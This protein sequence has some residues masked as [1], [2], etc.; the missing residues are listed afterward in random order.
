MASVSDC[1]SRS[2]AARGTQMPWIFVGLIY[3]IYITSTDAIHLDGQSF[4]EMNEEEKAVAVKEMLQKKKPDIPPGKE[5]QYRKDWQDFK[6]MTEKVHFSVKKTVMG[7]RA[8]ADRL[9]EVWWEYKL[10]CAAASLSCVIG[11]IIAHWTSDVRA[12]GFGLAGAIISIKAYAIQKDINSE[13]YRM[14]EKLLNETEESFFAVKD[15]I[16]EWSIAQDYLRLIY[17]YQLAEVQGVGPQVLATLREHIFDSLGIPSGFVRQTVT[18]LVNA[19]ARAA[20]DHLRNFNAALKTA[21]LVVDA[22][23]LG[24]TIKDLAENKGS[25]LAKDL[26]EKAKEIEDAFIK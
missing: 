25:N 18:H 6:R 24:F 4:S 2:F 11:G 17:I 15:K 13:D 10:R 7:L 3:I 23:E 26:R 21:L 19:G 12:M 22:I 9:D 5:L 14:V 8:L 20:R 1:C 16:S